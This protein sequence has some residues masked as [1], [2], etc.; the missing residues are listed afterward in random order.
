MNIAKDKVE[1]QHFTVRELIVRQ[2]LQSASAIIKA[3]G[4]QFLLVLPH[5]DDG[6]VFAASLTETVLD[7]TM[8]LAASDTLVR[9]L[10]YPMGK[11]HL[12]K[13]DVTVGRLAK[14]DIPLNDGSVSSLHALFKIRADGGRRISDLGS[15]NGTW[16]DD[17]AVA[18]EGE[19]N[20][21]DV[22]V[23]DTIR[24]GEVRTVF[25]DGASLHRLL[26]GKE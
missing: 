13:N 22:K 10:V 18:K 11:G 17:Q 21:V 14:Y 5:D 7:D 25:L 8:D 19:A 1:A 24:F 16:I 9:T 12:S 2:D 15:T 3:M 26:A 4:D 20:A 6:Q 23:G